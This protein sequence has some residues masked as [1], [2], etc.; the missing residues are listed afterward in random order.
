ML[1]L[2]TET[3]QDL[4]DTVDLAR[5]LRPDWSVVSL[6]IP[7]P[8]TRLARDY[9]STVPADIPESYYDDNYVFPGAA[10]PSEVVRRTCRDFVALVY[11]PRRKRISLE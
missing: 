5:R 4:R 9:P 7:Y 2:P 3:E 6:F 8:G 10:A 11:G 1:G